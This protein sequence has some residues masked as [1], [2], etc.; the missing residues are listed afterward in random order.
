MAV[1]DDWHEGFRQLKRGGPTSLV[2]A[3]GHDDDS[4]FELMWDS[5]WVPDQPAGSITLRARVRGRDGIWT[6]HDDPG[7]SLKRGSRH[8]QLIEPEDVPAA[9]GVRVGQTEGCTFQVP[10]G[11]TVTDARLSL[12]TWHGWD[13]H[14][15]PLR[16]NDARLPIDG[17]DHH[18]DQDLLP[19]P[20][21]AVQATNRFEV[22][23]ETDHHML[24]V[25]WPGPLLLIE[26]RD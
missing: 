15:V 18:F 17:A 9:F 4:P 7:Y 10:D 6:V 3:I 1:L 8:V 5:H 24:E 12:R 25:L 26:T 11:A 22:H 23:S 19:V 14:H 20:A 13:G 21:D 2:G 16:F